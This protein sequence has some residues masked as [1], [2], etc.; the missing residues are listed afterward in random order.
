MLRTAQNRK[1]FYRDPDTTIDEVTRDIISQNTVNQ[2]MAIPTALIVTGGLDQKH[3][4]TSLDQKND[5]Q[6][7]G[8]DVLNPFRIKFYPQQSKTLK[9]IM[10]SFYSEVFF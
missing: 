4:T 5:N 9:N 2:E 1:I 7:D 6:E 8:V 3:L 10:A